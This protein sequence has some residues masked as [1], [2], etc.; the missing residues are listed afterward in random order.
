MCMFPFPIVPLKKEY[1]RFY[2][3]MINIEKYLKYYHST[4]E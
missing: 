2:N 3:C 1:V 4:V